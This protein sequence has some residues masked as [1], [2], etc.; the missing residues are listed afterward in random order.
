MTSRRNTIQ[1]DLVRN[2]VCEM[3]RHVTANEVY[4]FVKESYNRGVEPGLSFWRD[5]TGNEV[6]LLRTV[7]GKK[8]AYEIK[9]GATYSPDFFKGISKWAKL[10]NTPTEQCFAIYNG[11]RDIKTSVGQV[12]GWNHFNLF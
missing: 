7:G 1:K 4:E 5:S 6:D 2:A 9:S 8:Y 3:K 11:D 12:N 10:S